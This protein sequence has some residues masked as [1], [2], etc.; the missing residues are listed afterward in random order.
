MSKVIS[1]VNMKGGV[2]KTTLSIALVDYI[3]AVCG[4][5]VCLV[6][7]DAQSNASYAMCGEERYEHT[8]T[9]RLTIDHFFLSHGR[10]FG[11]EQ[12]DEYIQP[13]I[14]RLEE[15]PPISLIASS[16]RLRLVERQILLKLARTNFFDE[17][18]EGRAGQALRDGFKEITSSG[19]YVVADSAPGI[20]GFS[21]AA[22]RA[23]D[24]VVAP[25]NP[26]YL[27]AIGLDLLGREIFPK[28]GVKLLPKLLAVRTK[29]RSGVLQPRLER[30]SD[31]EFQQTVG[32]S[33]MNTIIPLQADLG[34][35]VDEGDIVQSL[36]DK[37]G[38]GLECVV[39]FGAEVMKALE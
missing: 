33:L 20:S 23:S 11:G 31:E 15:Q 8:I 10:M 12:L 35:I 29:V 2:G 6:D 16:P 34:R 39:K 4:K 37:Y 36:R 18:L 5:P 1:I 9:K 14:S 13:Q 26:D 30:F 7:L 3:G 24:L 17:E 22:L 19:T 21:V 25:V 27:S 38:V 28:L 32:F